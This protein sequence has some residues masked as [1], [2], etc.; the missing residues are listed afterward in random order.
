M[1]DGEKEGGKEEG[2][3]GKEGGKRGDEIRAGHEGQ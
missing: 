1:R 3:R 2:E